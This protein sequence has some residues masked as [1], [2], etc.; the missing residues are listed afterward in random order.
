MLANEQGRKDTA[1]KWDMGLEKSKR[2]RMR[3][4]EREREKEKAGQERRK[5]REGMWLGK[6]KDNSEG[7]EANE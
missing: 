2:E 7:K 3:E 5:Q 6:E 1:E 4:G